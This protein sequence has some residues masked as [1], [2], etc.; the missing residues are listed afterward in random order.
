MEQTR[1]IFKRL[2]VWREER[3]L[4]KT[5]YSKVK[6]AGFIAEELTELLKVNTIEDELDAYC[7]EIIFCINAIEDAGFNASKCID[8]TLKEIESRK[9]EI[10]NGKF[11][12]FKDE[13]HKALWYK[14]DYPSCRR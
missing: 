5:T 14:A 12:K 1:D 8:E 10:R 9:G 13:K 6:H 2:K 7:D 11:E 4:D 3:G